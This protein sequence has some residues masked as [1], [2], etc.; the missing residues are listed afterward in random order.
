VVKIETLCD[1]SARPQTAVVSADVDQLRYAAVYI[2][3]SPRYL[4]A[5]TASSQAALPRRVAV[6]ILV[7]ICLLQVFR[8]I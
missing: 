8:G 4:G 5:V 7:Y 3:C 2:S 6:I 1:Q